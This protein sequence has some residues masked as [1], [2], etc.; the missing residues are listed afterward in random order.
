MADK[1]PQADQIPTGDATMGA[2]SRD[3]LGERFTSSTD[4]VALTGVGNSMAM[5]VWL[6]PDLYEQIKRIAGVMAAAEGATPPHL[7]KKP[8]ACFDVAVQAFTWRLNPMQVAKATYQTPGGKIGYEGKLVIAVLENSGHLVGPLEFAHYGRVIVMTDKKIKRALNSLDPLVDAVKNGQI[9]GWQILEEKDWSAVQGK[10]EVR[11]GEPKDGKEAKAYAHRVWQKPDAEGLGV[12]VSCQLK[13]EVKRR[14]YDFD[15]VQA[16]PLNSTLWA[17]DPKTQICYTAA[18]RFSSTVVSSI[19]MGVPFS[20]DALPD[21]DMR[22]V[23]P[24][25]ARRTAAPS[26]SAYTG[27]AGGRPAPID[28]D[29]TATESDATPADEGAAT[30]AGFDDSDAPAETDD[31]PGTAADLPPLHDHIGETRH[32][33][34]IDGMADWLIELSNLIYQAGEHMGKAELGQLIANNQDVLLN[35]DLVTAE[36]HAQINQSIAEAEARIAVRAAQ[37]E[38]S[39]KADPSHGRRTE[40]KGSGGKGGGG[41]SGLPL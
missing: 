9:E 40:P 10:Y 31:L 17:T 5:L 39:A 26:R 35:E 33:N 3:V 2:V 7:L 4:L 12:R 6:N 14:T 20:G 21:E 23:T 24:E 18:R 34:E 32:D 37:K 1:I 38:T 19:F 36:Q 13:G 41:Q 30:N 22:D 29:T 15:L 25:P 27:A 28:I 11:K 16:F 8:Y